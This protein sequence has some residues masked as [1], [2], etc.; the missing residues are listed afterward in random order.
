MSHKPVKTKLFLFM[1]SWSSRELR[2]PGGNPDWWTW[3]HWLYD[4]RWASWALPCLLVAKPDRTF[5]PCTD[6]RKVH[7][8]TKP[9]SYLLPQMEDCVD[10]VGSAASVN[11]FDLLKGYWKLHLTPRAREIALFITSSG[12]YSYTVMLLG[13]RNAPATFQ[14]LMKQVVPGLQ[15]CAIYLD[16]IVVYS[17]TLPENVQHIQTL[18]DR[19]TWANLMVNLWVC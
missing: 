11:K 2:F 15:G 3:G 10:Q 17:D 1:S 5:R 18:F 9:D 7:A 12:L 4:T 19:L 16:D 14:H 6:F 8:I 13:L